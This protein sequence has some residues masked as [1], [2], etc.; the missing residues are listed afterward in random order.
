MLSTIIELEEK[1]EM[2]KVLPML[3]QSISQDKTNV[4]LWIRYLFDGWYVL[5]EPDFDRLDIDRELLENKLPGYFKEAYELFSDNA[6]FMFYIGYI[7]SI[8]DW[9]FIDKT[10]TNGELIARY[11]MERAHALE[12]D[13]IIYEYFAKYSKLTHLD[14]EEEEKRVELYSRV[15]KSDLWISGGLIGNYFDEVQRRTPVEPW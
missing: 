9:Y 13:N 1:E 12:P 5:L 4:E 3:E 7:M 6:A 15:K 11:M 8:C 2:D 10:Q 14:A